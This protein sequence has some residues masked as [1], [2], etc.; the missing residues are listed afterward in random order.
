M[1]FTLDCEFNGFGGEL[2]SLALVAE[3]EWYLYLV[4]DIKEKVDPWVK[5]NVVP[6]IGKYDPIPSTKTHGAAA[7]K[8]FLEENSPDEPPVIVCDWP[9]DIK[10]FCEAILIGPGQMANIKDIIF[11]MIRYPPELR[12]ISHPDTHNAV[13]DAKCLMKLLQD[14]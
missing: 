3:N 4:F 14:S 13:H 1:I 2:I 12:D 9:D 5:L 8:K 11:R 10:Y 7:I 6:K